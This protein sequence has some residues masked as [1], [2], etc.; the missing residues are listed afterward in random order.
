MRLKLFLIFLILASSF[1][2]HPATFG[3]RL[4]TFEDFRR[5]DRVRRMTGQLHTAE[6]LEVT[7]V[8]AA[9]IMRTARQKADDPKVLWGA[10]E[11]L[12]D[13]P[14]KRA[15]FEAARQAAT[16]NLVIQLRYACAAAQNRD[17][18]LAL[19]SLRDYRKRDAGN[20]VA[21]WG[22]LWVLHQE[23]LPLP[24]LQPPGWVTYHDGAAEA[25][26]ARI[27]LLEAAGYSPYAAR[28]LGFMPDPSVISMARDLAAPPVDTNAAPVL[29]SVAKTM[30]DSPTFLLTELVGQTLERGVMASRPDAATSPEVSFR[31]VE[32]DKR[33]DEL[34]ALLADVERNAVEMATESEMV[35]YFD[36]VLSI[37]E[38]AAMKRLAE[39]V[40][41]KAVTP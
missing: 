17:F 9:L 28:R 12:A 13:W 7:H 36:D 18:D 40:R 29:L 14:N 33:R 16:S 15:M 30:Q 24:E 37:G 25:A 34:K 21:W 8:D 11:L 3:Q 2:L 35:Q 23:K 4:P 20:S 10:A 22:E 26:H 6:L 39:S 5:V 19:S 38:E 41:G 31:I 1:V 32:M 27:R